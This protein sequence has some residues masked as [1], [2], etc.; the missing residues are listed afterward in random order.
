MLPIG[1]SLQSPPR[2]TVNAPQY[3]RTGTANGYPR[4]SGG[5]PSQG[6]QHDGPLGGGPHRRQRSAKDPA[7]AGSD[8]P[9]VEDCHNSPVGSGAN[10]P[11][12]ALSQQQRG[13]C[14]GNL[15]EAVPAGLV[16]GPLARR[17]QRIV[18]ARE[19]DPVDQHELA[20]VTGHVEALPQAQR[21]EQAGVRVLRE[22][23]SELGQLCLALR[24]DRQVRQAFAR[25]LRG[26]LGGSAAGE[27]AQGTAVGGVDQVDDLVERLPV[28]P[29]PARRRQLPGDVQDRLAWIVE[30]RPDVDPAPWKGRGL[31]RLDHPGRVDHPRRPRPP[32]TPRPT[33][34]GSTPRDPSTTRGGSTTR[35]ASSS[36]WSTR[37][38]GLRPSETA[39]LVKS[40]PSISVAL[41]STTVF[42]ESS[43]S[44]SGPQTCKGATQSWS[45]PRARSR[46]ASHSTSASELAAIRSAVT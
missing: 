22:Q 11:P 4:S 27:Q 43:L 17:H 2:P 44:R 24:E 15:H 37:S 7:V 46:S 31:D 25:G 12:G 10:Q 32:R 21:P 1:T 9:W 16:G 8:Q 34:G 18:G 3:A 38:L 13:V 40:P 39:I 19:R 20:G 6:L 45:P 26:G 14:G 36:E 30:R 28:E 23:S 5:Q 42:C 33:R 35:D 29:V 41:V